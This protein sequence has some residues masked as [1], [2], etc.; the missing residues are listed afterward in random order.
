[1]ERWV[2]FIRNI[3]NIMNEIEY[4]DFDLMSESRSL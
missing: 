4:E 1:M 2:K 3:E